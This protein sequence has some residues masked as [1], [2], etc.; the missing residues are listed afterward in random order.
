MQTSTIIW[1]VVIAIAVIALIAVVARMASKK[2]AERNRHQAAE[3]REKAQAQ[4]G[5]LQRKEAMAKESE[6]KAAAARAEA[7]RKAAEAERLEAE[8]QDRMGTASEQRREHLEHLRKADELDP[9]V[10]HDAPSTDGRHPEGTTERTSA[11]ASRDGRHAGHTDADTADGTYADGET[12][13]SHR[14]T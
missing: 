12:H 8:A 13:G 6:A 7:D 3:L 4:A 11:D 2:K 1:I 10:K 9:D 14:R 5:D